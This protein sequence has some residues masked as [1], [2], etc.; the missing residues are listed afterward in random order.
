[1]IC[2][3]P[4]KSNISKVRKFMIGEP[5]DLAAPPGSQPWAIAVRLQ[6]QSLLKDNATSVKHLKTWIKGIEE[7]SGYLQLTDENGQLFSS[8]AAFCI[9]RPPWGLGYPP[10]VID[11]ILKELE[12]VEEKESETEY[13]QPKTWGKLEGYLERFSQV[14]KHCS[15]SQTITAND[16]AEVLNIAHN[17]ANIWRKRWLNLGWI[18][19]VTGKKNGLYQITDEGRKQVQDWVEQDSYKNKN[20]IWLAIPLCNPRKAAEQLIQCLDVDKL[21]ELYNII[22]NSLNQ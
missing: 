12:S 11:Q 16:I 9:A 22:G 14:I 2:R 18:E 21:Q 3:T 1:M 5:G 15:D 17:T 7:Y 13:K 6:I 10:E 20:E 8:F 19:L 4:V